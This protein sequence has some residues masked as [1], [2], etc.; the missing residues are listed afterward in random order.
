MG[1][2]EY[3][4]GLGFWDLRGVVRFRVKD[5]KGPSRMVS[6][7]AEDVTVWRVRVTVQVASGRVPAM[8]A[9]EIAAGL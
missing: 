9:K 4:W 7:L 6:C 5:K 2:G 1:L 3:G 8:L